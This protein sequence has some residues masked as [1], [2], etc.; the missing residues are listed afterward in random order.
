MEGEP[1]VETPNNIIRGMAFLPCR[2]PFFAARPRFSAAL[3]GANSFL[4]S[5]LSCKDSSTYTRL[6]SIG[7]YSSVPGGGTESGYS[8]RY[9]FPVREPRGG[10]DRK[11]FCHW[12]FVTAL[13]AG[14]CFVGSFS[15]GSGFLQSA[16]FLAFRSSRYL[17]APASYECSDKQRPS[18]G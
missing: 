1:L 3:A 7:W 11:P 4:P 14:A 2:R 15:R 17:A 16:G 12:S 6:D 5:F 9:R 13:F 10:D 8:G 18:S